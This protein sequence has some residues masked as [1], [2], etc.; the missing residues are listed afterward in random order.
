[1]PLFTG[2]IKRHSY[3][4]GG[5]QTMQTVI[6]RDYPYQRAL[7]GLVTL[8]IYVDH[9]FMRILGMSPP[10]KANSPHEICFVISKAY[11]FVEVGMRGASFRFPCIFVLN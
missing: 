7:F 3:L 5:D 11:L 8:A 2:D 4:E 1:M 6:F 9:C 10:Q